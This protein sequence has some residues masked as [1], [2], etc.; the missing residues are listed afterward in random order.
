MACLNIEV[1]VLPRATAREGSL[2]GTDVRTGS[3]QDRAG[4][5]GGVGVGSG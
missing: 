3:R 5:V 2:D 4:V 1:T